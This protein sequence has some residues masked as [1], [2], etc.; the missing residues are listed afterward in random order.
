MRKTHAEITLSV[1]GNEVVCQVPYRYLN[2]V[3]EGDGFY[4]D[5][6]YIQIALAHAAAVETAIRAKVGAHVA[7]KPIR[8][9]RSDFPPKA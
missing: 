4:S 9:E 5:K 8:L 7:G 2:Q 1:D 6:D 3:A